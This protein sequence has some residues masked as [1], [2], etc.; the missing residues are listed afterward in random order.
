MK[1]SSEK[2]FD[3]VRIKE[4]LIYCSLFLSYF[5][6]MKNT[7]INRISV[8]YNISGNKSSIYYKKDILSRNN[9]KQGILESSCQ[10][11]VE[12]GAINDSDNK[13]IEEIILKRNLIAHNLP[14][15][16]YSYD[17]EI[18]T[19]ILEKIKNLIIKIEKWWI[20]NFDVEIHPE[21]SNSEIDIDNIS[22]NKEM[23]LDFL[24]RLANTNVE[25]LQKEIAK[26][27]KIEK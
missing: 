23:L 10:W 3:A 21:L 1:N 7:I 2:H 19:E 9:K 8:F 6:I 22:I 24:F 13:N 14:D 16:L 17:F 25:L 12:K 5:E 11:L 20:V 4:T 15:I 18:D 27:E 26:F